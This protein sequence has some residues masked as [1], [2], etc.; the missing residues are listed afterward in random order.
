MSMETPLIAHV[1]FRFSI[2]GLENGVVNLINR[3]PE[4]AWRH[5]VIALTDVDDGFRRRIRRSDVACI[6][7]HKPPGHAFR[8]YPDLYRLFRELRPSVV[9]TRNLAALET[10]APAWA[11]RVPVRIH[12][13][14]GRDVTDLDG[15]NRR[16]RMVRRAFK[17]F[18]HHFVTVSR[19]LASYLDG[20]V[21]VPSSRITQIYNGVDTDAFHA[22]PASKP[23]IPGCTFSRDGLFLV[24]AVGRMEAV[25]DPANLARAFV[26]A[27]SRSPDAKARMRLVL[28]G[29][30]PQRAEA[31]R[32]VQEAGI[33]NLVWFAGER[34]DVPDV[35]RGLDCF[36][37]PSLAEGIS[38]TILEAMASGLP[39]V[40]T[41]VGGNADLM[42]EGMTGQLV[43]RADSGALAEAILGYFRDPATARRHG[44]A[45]RHRVEQHFSLDQMARQYERLYLELL[46]ASTRGRIGRQQAPHGAAKG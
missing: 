31:E 6:A 44:K 24:G 46:R 9:H 30:G 14:H 10:V 2:G 27:V 16:Y 42:I 18:V 34:S 43:P 1:V 23:A 20:A 4:T 7:L 41:R 25:K 29:D 11:A 8:L 12:G 40:A 37:L 22:A 13:E 5:A 26:T 45:G 39:V 3:M 19:D 15:S 35:M 28:V 21:G 36:V 32:I 38:N 17:P 33:G